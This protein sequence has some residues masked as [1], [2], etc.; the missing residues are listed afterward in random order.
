MNTHYDEK[1]KFFTPV[2]SKYPV[3]VIIQTLLNR[4][5]GNIYIRPDERSKDAVNTDEQFIAMTDV[6]ISNTQGK[7]IFDSDFLLVNRD[8]IVWIFPRDENESE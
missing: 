7:K 2:V 4:I 3:H 1:G 5:E 8:H 6:S